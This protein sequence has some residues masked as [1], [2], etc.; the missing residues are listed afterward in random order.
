MFMVKAALIT[1]HPELGIRSQPYTLPANLE[2]IA[3]QLS[4]IR[5]KSVKQRDLVWGIHGN[6]AFVSLP[7]ES[8]VFHFNGCDEHRL[9]FSGPTF[10]FYSPIEK[11]YEHQG[12]LSRSGN[13]HYICAD[14][15][16]PHDADIVQ[17][18]FSHGRGNVQLPRAIAPLSV[19]DEVPRTGEPPAGASGRKG[20]GEK[21]GEGDF[22]TQVFDE[23]TAAGF[24]VN[25]IE[26]EGTVL[27]LAASIDQS[28][29]KPGQLAEC[30]LA[31]DPGCYV[32]PPQPGHIVSAGIISEVHFDPITF[33]S[34]ASFVASVLAGYARMLHLNVEAEHVEPEFAME[35]L[36][37]L[38]PFVDLVAAF[39]KAE[40]AIV[41]LESP[42]LAPLPD[43]PGGRGR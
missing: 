43:E 16:G 20:T 30:E 19:F 13:F 36:A 7:D 40:P 32:R 6:A 18:L 34:P 22:L 15:P 5:G 33:P 25:L 42:L 1:N 2:A 35:L 29:P 9:E 4:L 14:M 3:M 28:Q 11:Q 26:H 39:R 23:M 10:L 24:D 38:E 8:E 27:G 17:T 41:A 21:F 12:V 37:M 31:T